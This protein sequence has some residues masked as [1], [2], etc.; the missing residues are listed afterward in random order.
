[1]TMHLV[2]SR[3]YVERRRPHRLAPARPCTVLVVEDGDALSTSHL[4]SRGYRI[5]EVKRGADA[6]PVFEREHCDCVVFDVPTSDSD[7]FSAC[8]RLRSLPRGGAAAIVFLTALRDVD[9]FERAVQAGCDDFVSKPTVAGE[10]LVRIETALK[11]RQLRAE[12]PRH[13]ELLKRRHEALM[14]LQ[15]ERERLVAFIVHDLKNPV[16]AMD[17]HAQVLLREPSLSESTHE[18]LAQIRTGARQLNRMILNILDVSK[19]GEG[20]LTAR[21][22]VVD[23]RALVAAVIAE[24]EMHA[25]ARNVKIREALEVPVVHGDEDLLHRML[26]NLVENATR[27]APHGGEVTVTAVPRAGGSEIRVADDGEGVPLQMRERIFEAFVQAEVDGR[28]PAKG[29]RGLGLT[30]CKAAAMAH[31]GRIWVED[32]APGAAFCVMLP[33]GD[34]AVPNS[35]RS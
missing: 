30:F 23:L 18:S 20:K 13:Y 24:L 1:M 6:L 16:S 21:R 7:A 35:A 12:H 2:R 33:D 29:G 4:E 28:P 32:A 22:A 5:I 9:T 27:H 10:L 31:G 34:D 3:H 17:L 11:L 8:R 25:H 26:V 19:A 14:R 15:L